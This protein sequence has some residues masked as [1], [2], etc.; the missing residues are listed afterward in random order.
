VG[1]PNP[2]RRFAVWLFAASACNV[3]APLPVSE[4]VTQESALR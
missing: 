2:W 1:D 4:R 3:A